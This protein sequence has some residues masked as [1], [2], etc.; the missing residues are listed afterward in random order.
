MHLRALFMC[1]SRFMCP[2][3][4]DQLWSH[5]SIYALLFTFACYLACVCLLINALTCNSLEQI[6]ILL[7]DSNFRAA[8][9]IRLLWI[10]DRNEIWIGSVLPRILRS[11][12]L[13]RYEVSKIPFLIHRMFQRAPSI[14]IEMSSHH[15]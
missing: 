11:I 10:L 5:G 1:L 6:I 14:T 9:L 7:A 15:K 12:A 13:W 3:L 8:Q 4:Q 2:W